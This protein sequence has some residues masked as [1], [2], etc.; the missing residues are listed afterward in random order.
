MDR[1]V[2]A[3]AGSSN[4]S[5]SFPATAQNQDQAR[6]VL[7]HASIYGVQVFMG[8]KMGAFAQPQDRSTTIGPRFDHLAVAP[9]AAA[10]CYPFL[11]RAFYAVVGTQAATPSPL[12]IVGAT[13]I[14]AVA[15]V[16]PFLA[17][18]LAR[19][20]DA[21]PGARRLAYA[22]VT[23]PTLYVFLGVVQTLIHSPIPDEIVWC[24]CFGLR[25]RFCHRPPAI[26]PL[27]RG[28]P[29]DA[30]ASSTE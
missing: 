4:R 20:R 23:A 1:V 6:V 8:F 25:S 16:V 19:R 10:I 2:D 11:L 30:G 13:L 7:E 26:R 15:F 5:G 17:L 18:A 24:V 14:L 28:R 21:D 3:V 12:A 22:G 9:A 27:K 29:W